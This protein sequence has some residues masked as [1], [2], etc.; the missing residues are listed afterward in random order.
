MQASGRN[1]PVASAKPQTSPVGSADSFA[2]TAYAVPEVPME[3]ATSPSSRP[4]PSAAPML[5]PVPADSA[6]PHEVR[7]TT[8]DGPATRGSATGR[9]SARSAYSGSHAPSAGEK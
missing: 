4:S 3:T 7:P 8:S 5:S 9:P 1:R 6:A 2:V